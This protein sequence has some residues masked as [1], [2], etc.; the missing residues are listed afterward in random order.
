ARNWCQKAYAFFA[1]SEDRF[2][3]ENPNFFFWAFVY[4]MANLVMITM[5]IIVMI[6]GSSPSFWAESWRNTTGLFVVTT[7]T[8]SFFTFD[9]VIR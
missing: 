2:L 8:I 6:I 5:A 4:Q 1:F 3:Q 9:Y 7:I